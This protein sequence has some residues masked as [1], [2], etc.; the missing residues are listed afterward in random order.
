MPAGPARFWGLVVVVRD[1]GW[2][3]SQLGTGGLGEVKPA[4]QAG[5]QIATLKRTAGLGQPVAFMTPEPVAFMR[6]KP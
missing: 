6:P 5:R 1:L 3:A 2:L 4:V